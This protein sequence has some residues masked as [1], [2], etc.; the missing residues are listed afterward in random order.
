MSAA[1]RAYLAGEGFE[2]AFG[3]R[4]LKRV[5]QRAVAN[6]LS[7]QLLSGTVQAGDVVRV[8]LEDGV[9]VFHRVSHTSAAEAA[10]RGAAA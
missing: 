1:A 7:K 6:P 3:A 5:L 8:D 2:P 4:P 10:V 9:V